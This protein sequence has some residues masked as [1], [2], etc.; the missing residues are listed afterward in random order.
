MAKNK[1]DLDAEEFLDRV[2]ENVV[3]ARKAKGFS[4]L[5]LATEMG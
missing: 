5:Q 1:L 3:N 4:Q 2:S